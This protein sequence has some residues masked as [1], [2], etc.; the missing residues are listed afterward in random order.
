M[1]EQSVII[2]LVGTAALVGFFF[3]LWWMCRTVTKT[4][5]RDLKQAKRNYKIEELKCSIPCNDRELTIIIIILVLIC[6]IGLGYME[7]LE[8]GWIG[9]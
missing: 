7:A 4:I 1:K 6:L 2:A 3:G 5:N 9:F 8:R